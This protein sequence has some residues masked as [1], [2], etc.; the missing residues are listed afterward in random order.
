MEPTGVKDTFGLKA[1]DRWSTTAAV[2][3]ILLQGGAIATT[4][5]QSEA[6]QKDPNN[7]ND[8]SLLLTAAGLTVA[9]RTLASIEQPLK[10]R[11]LDAYKQYIDDLLEDL[12]KSYPDQPQ[13]IYKPYCNI[14]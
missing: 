7:T 6:Q 12:K 1:V 3:N 10:S 9:T 4:W 13:G 2:L 8:Y 5:M 11:N 14:M